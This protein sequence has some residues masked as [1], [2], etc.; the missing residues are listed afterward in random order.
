MFCAPNPRIEVVDAFEEAKGLEVLGLPKIA[1]LEPEDP[2]VPAAGVFTEEAKG[3]GLPNG[4]GVLAELAGVVIVAPKELKGV[5]TEGA[6]NGKALV[7]GEPKG[8]RPAEDV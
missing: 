6:P 2:N 1:V 8:F 7:A 3:L 4:L 5:P